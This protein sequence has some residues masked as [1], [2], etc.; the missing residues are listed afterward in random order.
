MEKSRQ[1][2]YHTEVLRLIKKTRYYQEVSDR[3]HYTLRGQKNQVIGPNANLLGNPALKSFKEEFP[4]DKLLQGTVDYSF[5]RDRFDLFHLDTDIKHV[6]ITSKFNKVELR[7]YIEQEYR[8]ILADNYSSLSVIVYNHQIKYGGV[9][10]SGRNDMWGQP[11][12]GRNNFVSYHEEYDLDYFEPECSDYAWTKCEHPPHEWCELCVTDDPLDRRGFGKPIFNRPTN[13]HVPET[14]GK[15]N[16]KEAETSTYC[17]L[18][19]ETAPMVEYQPSPGTPCSYTVVETPPRLEYSEVIETIPDIIYPSPPDFDDQL[20]LEPTYEDPQHTD[21]PTEY[22]NV[23]CYSIGTLKCVRVEQF[24]TSHD[25]TQVMYYHELS[26]HFGNYWYQL[27]YANRA[28][29]SNVRPTIHWM[30]KIRL[31]GN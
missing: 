24:E 21:L 11:L 14:S 6:T 20:L 23:N 28:Y 18:E 27:P 2:S 4:F 31:K 10:N 26:I 19:F 29:R 7:A 8:R 12:L 9:Q 15:I 17:E 16:Q 5:L 3:Y 13:V 30:V 25:C 22:T 1:N